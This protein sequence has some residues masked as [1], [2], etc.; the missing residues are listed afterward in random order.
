MDIQPDMLVKGRYDFSR[1]LRRVP[2]LPIPSAPDISFC[3]SDADLE[4]FCQVASWN[5][6]IR[7]H[8]A[9]APSNEIN[10]LK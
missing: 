4:H 7:H 3:Y 9:D 5:E 8:G 1:T 6:N 2:P 10:Y